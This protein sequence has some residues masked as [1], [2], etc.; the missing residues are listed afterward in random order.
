MTDPEFLQTHGT[1][2]RFYHGYLVVIIAFMVMMVAQGLFNSFGIVFNSLL[3]EFKW[4]RAVTA[5][6]FSLSMSLRGLVGILM[7]GLTDRFGPRI[8]LS[9][10]GIALGL[11]YFLMSRT[12]ELWQ[13]YIFYGVLLGSGMS[14]IWVPLLSS[15]ARWFDRRRSLMTGFVVAGVGIGGFIAPPLISRL[16]EASDWRV[17]Y[18]VQG[19]VA[20]IVVVAAAQ[21]LRRNTAQPVH[22]KDNTGGPATIVP[23]PAGLTLGVA[24]RTSQLWLI[25]LAFACSGYFTFSLLVHLVPHAVEL[26][27]SSVDAS[28]LLATMNGIS[29]LGILGM[30]GVFGDRYGS[31][32]VFIISMVMA[33]TALVLLV[34]AT[35]VWTL[36]IFVAI[37]GI[38]IGALGASE[39][40][41]IARLFGLG[42]HG[43][44]FG[45]CGLGFTAGTALGPLVTGYIFDV[46]GS[47]RI[48]FII[49]AAVA[50]VG[51]IAV[52]AVKPIRHTES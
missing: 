11:G 35:E 21:F 16:I 36:Y 49:C 1:K 38:A 6:A 50:A 9:V 17:S 52:S 13:L 31:R 39:S 8:V 45:V 37:L 46:T 27:I 32:R 3:D 34:F 30:A 23:E 47:Y 29:L 19:G 24:A 40:P 41:L 7:G 20:L 25:L 5:G 42:S 22:D 43:L 28:T 2:P 44:I 18:L 48:A 26:G 51:L 33:V 10:C 12:T 15:V 4:T 14:G